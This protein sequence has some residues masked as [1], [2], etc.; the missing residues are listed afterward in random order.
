MKSKILR[1]TGEECKR[2]KRLCCAHWKQE[3]EQ[4]GAKQNPRSAEEEGAGLPVTL[5]NFDAAANPVP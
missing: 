4:H 5:S 2:S 3:S 1:K